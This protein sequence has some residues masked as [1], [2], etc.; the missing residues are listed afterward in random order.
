MRFD[1]TTRGLRVI[2]MAASVLLLA[3]CAL[4]TDPGRLDDASRD[5][6]RNMRRWHDQGYFSYDYVI[7]NQCFC[8]LG[9]VPVRVAV[10]GNQVVSVTFVSDGQPLPTDL[11]PFYRDVE[12]LFQ[13]IEDAID[14]RAPTITATY[15]T[16]FGYPT[17]VYI[18]HIKNAADDESGFRVTSL[19]P[20]F[21]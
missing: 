19:S 15:H 17:D 14:A 6:S 9:G 5:L 4:I 3:A 10:R 8:V 21:R 1:R 18:D 12:G 20:I 7:S 2:A 11:A 16:E 13:M